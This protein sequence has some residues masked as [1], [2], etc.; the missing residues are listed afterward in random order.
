MSDGQARVTLRLANNAR[1]WIYSPCF[2]IQIWYGV[3]SGH[4]LAWHDTQIMG[5]SKL[6]AP[7]SLAG[8]TSTGG[9]YHNG[10]VTDM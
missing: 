8:L 6:A 7:F 9:E 2:Y 5:L 4:H 10:H 3:L 1:E